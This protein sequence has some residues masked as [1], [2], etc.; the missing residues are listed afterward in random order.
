M[1]GR[2]HKALFISPVFFDLSEK[3]LKVAFS[4]IYFQQ[5]LMALW[6]QSSLVSLPQTFPMCCQHILHFP[7]FQAETCL[8]GRCF[9]NSF[10]VFL[11]RSNKSCS[12]DNV[13]PTKCSPFWNSSLQQPTNKIDYFSYFKV[14]PVTVIPQQHGWIFFKLGHSWFILQLHSQ[15]LRRSQMSHPKNLSD[16]GWEIYSCIVRS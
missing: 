4:G 2:A 16:V 10:P 9:K 12:Q 14:F 5:P 7:Q 1:Q 8:G 13:V 15:H 6:I 3:R 11:I